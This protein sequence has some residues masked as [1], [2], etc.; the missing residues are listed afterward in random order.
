MRCRTLAWDLETSRALLPVVRY[1]Q[2]TKDLV[3]LES[4]SDATLPK[5]PYYLTLFKTTKGSDS[6]VQ[7]VKL[8][9]ET[10]TT[11]ICDLEVYVHIPW[12]KIRLTQRSTFNSLYLKKHSYD[13]HLPRGSKV[14]LYVP[15]TCGE[16]TTTKATRKLVNLPPKPYEILTNPSKLTFLF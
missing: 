12:E 10:T 5:G 15:A 2:G 4:S 11:G 9:F 7:D 3:V 14:L 1:V 16:V 8:F 13:Q 6:Y